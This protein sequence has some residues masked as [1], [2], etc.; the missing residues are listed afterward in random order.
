MCDFDSDRNR[1]GRDPAFRRSDNQSSAENFGGAFAV[2]LNRKKKPHLNRRPRIQGSI[3]ANEHAGNADVFRHSFMPLAFAPDPIPDRGPNL[4]PPG[5]GYFS[6]G[7]AHSP[8]Q[9]HPF[10]L[11]KT[12][13]KPSGN[14]HLIGEVSAIDMRGL[15]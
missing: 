14:C 7:C 4:I 9:I 3:G 6:R 10:S 11:S 1:I 13:V 5:S 15:G 2:Q 12:R 8:L